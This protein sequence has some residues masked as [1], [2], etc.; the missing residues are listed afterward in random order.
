[1]KYTGIPKDKRNDVITIHT[2]ETTEK[3]TNYYEVV[4]LNKKQ[5][6]EAVENDG[7]YS[8]RGSSSTDEMLWMDIEVSEH[9]DYDGTGAAKVTSSSQ[10]MPCANYGRKLGKEGNGIGVPYSSWMFCQNITQ[11]PKH[12]LDTNHVWMP[13]SIP[14]WVRDNPLCRAC[15]ANIKNGYELMP[16]V[17]E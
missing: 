15:R 9:R 8:K 5:A 10:W 13:T 14:A 6:K 12:T 16:E 2:V 17:I 11:I 4:G 7:Y 3:V 1:M